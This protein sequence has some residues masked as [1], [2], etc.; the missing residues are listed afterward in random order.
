MLFRSL[1]PQFYFSLLYSS[2]LNS[3]KFLLLVSLILLFCPLSQ[4]TKVTCNPPTQYQLGLCVGSL[5]K[6]IHKLYSLYAAAALARKPRN[7]AFEFSTA[8]SDPSSSHADFA[9]FQSEP[10][11]KTL[12]HSPCKLRT[13]SR[14]HFG[15]KR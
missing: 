8:R 2:F 5:C 1:L 13:Q 3:T 15:P 9:E 4:V 11:E 6:P 14:G 7:L 12:K 10:L